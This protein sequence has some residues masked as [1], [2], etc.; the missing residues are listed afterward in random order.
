MNETHGNDWRG[1]AQARE[2][3]RE[4]EGKPDLGRLLMALS[5]EKRELCEVIS[6]ISKAILLKTLEEFEVTPSEFQEYVEDLRL[7]ESKKKKS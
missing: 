2:A 6:Y 4:K 7:K 1:K 5:K 3:L